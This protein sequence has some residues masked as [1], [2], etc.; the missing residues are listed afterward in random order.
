[1]T[2]N[3]LKRIL[4]WCVGINYGIL[5]I[6]FGAFF[7]AHDLLFRLHSHWFKLSVEAFDSLHYGCMGIYKIGILLFNLVPLVAIWLA[8]RRNLNVQADQGDAS[9]L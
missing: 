4:L 2:I 6:W 5:L 8:A 7:L 3:E 1:M 9:A